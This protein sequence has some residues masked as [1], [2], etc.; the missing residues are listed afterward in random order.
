MYDH[1][2][3]VGGIVIFSEDMTHVKRAEE[4]LKKTVG[5]LERS[6]RELQQFAYVS[7]HDLQEPLRTVTSYTHSCRSATGGGWTKR[8]IVT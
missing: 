7:S 3:N 6:N 5:E 8:R 2:G 1:W 4:D